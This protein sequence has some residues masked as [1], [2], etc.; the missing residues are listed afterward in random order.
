MLN[1]NELAVLILAAGESKRMGTTIKQLLPWKST[2]LVGHAI[3]QAKEV[4]DIVFVVLGANKERIK[5]TL[6]KDLTI[7]ENQDWNKGMGASIAIGV[8]EISENPNIKA[9]LIMLAD[10][11]LL[12]AGYFLELKENF[13]KS[14]CN[15]VATSYA[16]KNGVPALFDASLFSELATLDKDYGARKIMQKHSNTLISINPKGK[17]V[18]I[19][20]PNTYEQLKNQIQDEV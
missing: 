6:E 1:R 8:S 18:D 19:D 20:T 17:A 16:T 9:I 4:S 12:E 5:S 10:Q 11:P 2:N 3:Q 15:I 7:I 13:S 14:E